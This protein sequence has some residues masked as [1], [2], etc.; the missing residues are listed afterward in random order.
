MGVADNMSYKS[1]YHFKDDYTYGNTDKERL[2]SLEGNPEI[3]S[4]IKENPFRSNVEIEKD[5]L[6]LNPDLTAIFKAVGKKHSNGGIDVNLKPNS[7]VFSDDKSLAFTE[8]DHKL[9][10]FKKG[11]S[12]A[13]SKNTPA[14]VLKRNIDIKHY[15]KMV[16]IITDP[17][18]EDIDKRTATMMLEKYLQSV[19]N[20]AFLQEQKKDFPD[21]VPDFAANTAPVYEA[22][23]KDTIMQ[24]KQFARYG[25]NI[26]AQLGMALSPA[27]TFKSNNQFQDIEVPFEFNGA[28]VVR[29]N[30]KLVPAQNPAT[31]QKATS[32]FLNPANPYL[33]YQLP[34][35]IEEQRRAL[36]EGALPDFPLPANI[37]EQRDAL[38]AGATTDANGNPIIVKGSGK[39]KQGKYSGVEPVAP[40]APPNYG[41]VGPPEDTT[42]YTPG[43]PTAPTTLSVPL[44]TGTPQGQKRADWRFTPEQ[45]ISQGYNLY[46]LASA[47]RYMPMR[48]RFNASF[49]DPNLVNP[50]QAVGD[51]Q[52]STNQAL[53]GVNSS[54]NPIMRNAQAAGIYG[55]LLNKLPGV[56]SAYDNQNAQIENQ[57]A[58]YNNQIKNQ[59]AQ[60]NMANDQN[61]YKE[62]ITGQANFDNMKNYLG[63]QYMNNRTQD[64]QD[65]QS[66]AYNLLTQNNPAY[67]F[68]WDSGNFTRTNK[69]IMDAQSDSKSDL[70]T[71]LATSMSAKLR[72][73]EKLTKEEVDFFK[74]LSLGKLQFTP[75]AQY[76]GTFNPY[77]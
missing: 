26:K 69:S 71:E 19:G 12:F 54:L 3:N 31:V 7:F 40:I 42:D 50:E 14:E 22:D 6:V 8:K 20:V 53:A 24:Q 23:L 47:K 11:G 49:V 36:N 72:R 61:Y 58:Q 77:K 18:A 70:Y 55:D 28:W 76:G 5:E 27:A 44:V 51:L 38:N 45:R 39:P 33:P 30:G 1:M 15:N 13:P 59:A 25:G 65:N 17:K 67:N 52:M 34:A 63:D 57:T 75:R 60:I 46:K 16:S 21:G 66:L 68:D 74:G 62:T 37:Q 43:T 4:T 64:V 2:P 41:T 29:R 48:S 32:S 56:R 9:F 10:E 35:N 73:G